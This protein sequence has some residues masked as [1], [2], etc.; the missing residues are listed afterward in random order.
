MLNEAH[1][2][3]KRGEDVVVGIVET[4]GRSE[5]EALLKDLEM[6]PRRRVEYQGIVLEEL[7]LDAILS[8]RPAVVL[9]DELAHTNAPGA[10]I[11]N[12]IGMLK[13]CSTAA[14]MFIQR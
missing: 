9:V 11:P 3:K 1:V 10:A 6:I 2:L 14:L 8:R 12:D 13:N 5:T 4:H 7:D